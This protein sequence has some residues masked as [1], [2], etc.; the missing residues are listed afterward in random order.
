M[1]LRAVHIAGTASIANLKVVTLATPFLQIY[2]HTTFAEDEIDYSSP[3]GKDALAFLLISVSAVLGL[4]FAAAILIPLAIYQDAMRAL[5]PPTSFIDPFIAAIVATMVLAIFVGG[6]LGLL[7]L[8]KVVNPHATYSSEWGRDEG[9]PEGWAYR[10]D[11]L[12]NLS[13][14]APPQTRKD[15]LLVLRGVDDEASLTLAAGSIGNRITHF[16]LGTLLPNIYQVLALLAT[17]MAGASAAGWIAPSLGGI[18]ALG[19]GAS[20]FLATVILALP[21]LFRLVFGR[22]LLLGCWRCE[23]AANSSPDGVDGVQVKTLP[24]QPERSKR[25]LRHALY[26]ND[27]VPSCIAEW[28]RTG[29][30]AAAP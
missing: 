17:L 12:A 23:I 13:F 5:F 3:L 18:I 11:R 8:K 15:W 7:L 25:K 9:G 16:I 24:G 14:Y 2:T 27:E 28:L 26:M 6:R 21:G 30:S 19:Y 29:T 22:E 4:P 10:P 1:A 20:A